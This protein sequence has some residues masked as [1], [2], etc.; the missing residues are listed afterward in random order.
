MCVFG[1]ETERRTERVLEEV[2][3]DRVAIRDVLGIALRK[4]S[5]DVSESRKGFVDGNRFLLEITNDSRL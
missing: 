3:E 5:D 1:E 4:S 2:S